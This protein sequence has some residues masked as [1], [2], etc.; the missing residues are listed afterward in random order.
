LRTVANP[1]ESRSRPPQIRS[2]SQAF[3][4]A[5]SRAN[6]CDSQHSQ[7][8]QGSGVQL[9][10]PTLTVLQRLTAWGWPADLA[11]ATATRI[12]AR[13]ADDVRRTC[14]ECNH[15]RPGAHRCSRHRAAALQTP[16]LARDLAALPQ[17]C[18]AFAGAVE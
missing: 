4:E 12:Q 11:E 16:E 1:C 6:A 3:A 10:R 18:P 13:Q 7:H 5:E 15:Y 8:S 2:H 14:V 17:H 9:H